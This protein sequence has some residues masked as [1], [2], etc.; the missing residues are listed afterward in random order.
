MAWCGW[1]GI[2]AM[3]DVLS[4]VLTGSGFLSA[5]HSPYQTAENSNCGHL[6]I[7]LDIAARSRRTTTRATAGKASCFRTTPSPT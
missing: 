1:A 4:G 2:A 3:V 6:V 7:A 5:V